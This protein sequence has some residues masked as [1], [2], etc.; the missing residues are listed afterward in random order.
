M[1]RISSFRWP[2]H[3]EYR[4]ELLLS[5][6]AKGTRNRAHPSGNPKR[7]IRLGYRLMMR[8][9]LAAAALICIQLTVV[10]SAA[11]AIGLPP[12]ATVLGEEI[13]TTDAGKM[14]QIVLTRLLDRY[15]EEQ[16]IEASDAEIETYLDNM[17]RGM[18][19][20]GLTAEDQL[21]PDEAVQVD[22]MR[23]DMARS[24][25]RHWKLNLALYRQYHGRI[26]FQQLGPEPL[27]A[28]RQYLEER[29]AAGDFTIHQKA[30]EDEFWRYFTSDSMH[31]FYEPGSEAE[32]QV[33]NILGME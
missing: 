32:A 31:D 21:T 25:I 1:L 17:R 29:H 24:M 13:R 23:R 30:F 18:R 16:H 22:Q 4:G 12:A 19:A 14:Q 20:A 9:L 2:L 33:K 10:S 27:D 11:P 28:Y 6:A 26:I 15:A 7:N 8:I 5:L 3:K